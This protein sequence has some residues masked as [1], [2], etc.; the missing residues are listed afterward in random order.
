MRKFL[1]PLLLTGSF[2]ANMTFQDGEAIELDD[3]QNVDAENS[4]EK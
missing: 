3:S 2:V 1:L 4:E